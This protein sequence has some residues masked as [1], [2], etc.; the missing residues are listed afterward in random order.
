MLH[1]LETVLIAAQQGTETIKKGSERDFDKSLFFLR[2]I[3]IAALY[4]NMP[5]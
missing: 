4:E 1:Q 5:L 2:K 3:I